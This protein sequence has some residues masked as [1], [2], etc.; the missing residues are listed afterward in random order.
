MIRQALCS[1]MLKCAVGT[2]LP[3]WAVETVASVVTDISGNAWQ[4]VE[5]LLS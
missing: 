1:Q 5:T 4:S 3:P 2:Q